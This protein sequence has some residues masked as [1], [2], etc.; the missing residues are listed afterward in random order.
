MGGKTNGRVNKERKLGGRKDGFTGN[1]DFWKLEILLSHGLQQVAKDE[2]D[3]EGVSAPSRRR[4]VNLI[5]FVSDKIAKTDNVISF[6]QHNV[7][8]R[9]SAI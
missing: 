1:G 7:Q 3:P 4:P 9:I 5:L 2:E 8:N 6:T